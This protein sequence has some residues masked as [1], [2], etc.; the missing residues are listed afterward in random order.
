MNKNENKIT[1]A[2]LP[3]NLRYLIVFFLMSLSLGVALGLVYV[4]TTTHFSTGGI[5]N[6]YG[7]EKTITSPSD[8]L[9]PNNQQYY[10]KTAKELLMTTH[11]H[12]LSLSMIFFA[13]SLLAFFTESIS[14]WIKKI[15]IFEPFVS[16]WLTFLGMWGVRFVDP[17]FKYLIFFSSI[18]LYGLFFITMV[19][20]FY[21]LIFLPIVRKNR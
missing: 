1:L 3:A 15:I 14:P 5:E 13:L 16:I 12:I 2:K 20:L 21:E 17:T 10:A 11:N 19:I 6:N 9:E 8:S 4:F 18:L 7:G